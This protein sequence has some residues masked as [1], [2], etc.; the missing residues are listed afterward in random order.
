MH[1]TDNDS[2]G[3]SSGARGPGPDLEK[4]HHNLTCLLKQFVDGIPAFLY[5]N[6]MGCLLINTYLLNNPELT[7]QGVIFGSP[8]FGFPRHIGVTWDRKILAR[9]IAPVFESFAMQGTVAV[10]RVGQ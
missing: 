2:F 7:L 1:I 10:N 4:M 5:G 3:Y 8:F 6:S 9:L